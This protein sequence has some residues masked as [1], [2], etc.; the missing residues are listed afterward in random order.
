MS[1]P[2]TY[3]FML[4]IAVFL[5]W[6]HEEN[7]AMLENLCRSLK[8]RGTAYIFLTHKDWES[9]M[10]IPPRFYRRMYDT[11]LRQNCGCMYSIGEFQKLLTECGFEVLHKQIVSGFWGEL[12]WE[13]DKIFKE[14]N[15]ERWKVF[16]LPALKWMSLADLRIHNKKG[17][18]MIFLVR[19]SAPVRV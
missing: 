13:I 16:F 4:C 17:T 2:D 7:R 14:R 1:H 18:G 9:A 19:K 3:D 11:F 10:I 12:A 8:E 6:S 15:L 5:C